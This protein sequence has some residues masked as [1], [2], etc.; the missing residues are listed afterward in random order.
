MTCVCSLK[1][2]QNKKKKRKKIYTVTH[3][4]N[5]QVRALFHVGCFNPYVAVKLVVKTL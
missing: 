2:H 1:I 4:V 5:L 3:D